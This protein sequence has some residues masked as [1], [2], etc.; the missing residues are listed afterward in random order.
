[1]FLWA[2]ENCT[3]ICILNRCPHQ[4]LKDKTPGEAFTG[5]KPYV[6][7]FKVFGSPIYIHVPGVKRTKLG[8]SILNGILPGYNE[9]STTYK[10]YVSPKRKILVS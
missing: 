2:E 4:V 6:S 8:P 5:E 9:F 3:A 1:M 10:I 7:H